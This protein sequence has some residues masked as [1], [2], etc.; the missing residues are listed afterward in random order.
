M[1]RTE[2][3]AAYKERPFPPET[4][5]VGLTE[6]LLCQLTEDEVQKVSL[7]AIELET[8]KLT[9]FFKLLKVM[10]YT[11]LLIAQRK[12]TDLPLEW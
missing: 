5:A 3:L 8:T 11:Q 1:N 10:A 9:L 12:K 2:L 7:F 6:K 4:V